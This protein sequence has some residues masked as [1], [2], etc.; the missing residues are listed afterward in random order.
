MHVD[1]TKDAQQNSCEF[2]WDDTAI[3]LPGIKSHRP[4]S[5]E[6]LRKAVELIN[7]A[8]CPLIFA[9]HGVLLSG[10][11]D[12][13]RELAERGDIPVAM[14][15]L[16]IGGFPAQHPLNLGMMG[17][18]G[19]AWVNHAIQEADLI[20]ACGM[21]FDDRVTG[22]LKNYAP[23]SKKIHIDIDTTEFNT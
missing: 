21:R 23:N 11:A 19:E 12:V 15:L 18:H 7:Q 22:N 10:A 17:M 6:S 1:I 2:V 3:S 4:V 13:L 8:K 20:V 14:T 9:G 16:G 5:A